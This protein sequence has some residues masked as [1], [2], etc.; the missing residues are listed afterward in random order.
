MSQ[1]PWRV[2]KRQHPGSTWHEILNEP[3]WS[4]VGQH[5]IGYR[6]DQDRIAGITYPYEELSPEDEEAWREFQELK[7]REKG[8]DLVNF[9]DLIEHQRVSATTLWYYRGCTEFTRLRTS[10]CGDRRIAQSDGVTS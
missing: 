9:R 8:G 10:I 5:R 2:T 6:N 1:N 3:D 7:R 4:S